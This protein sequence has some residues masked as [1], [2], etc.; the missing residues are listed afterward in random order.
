[1]QHPMQHPMYEP[2]PPRMPS[3]QLRAYY[4]NQSLAGKVTMV[5]LYWLGYIPRLIFTFMIV[6]VLLYV[7][8]VWLLAVPPPRIET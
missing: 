4:R 6:V 2:A 1:M 3:P 8:F 5:L 7:I